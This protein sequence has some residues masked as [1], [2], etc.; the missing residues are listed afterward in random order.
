[1]VIAFVADLLLVLS[2]VVFREALTKVNA[3]MSWPLMVH[4]PIAVFTV[5]LYGVTVYTGY[6]LYKGA[7]VRQ[8][9]RILD[10][11]L[12]PARVLTLFTSLLVEFL[13]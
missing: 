8:R 3:E 1:M 13:K 11:I 5:I 10:R 12:V 2:L 6:R 7:P 4:V 9:L